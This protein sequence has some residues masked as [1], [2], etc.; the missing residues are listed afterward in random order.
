MARVGLGAEL[1]PIRQTLLAFAAAASG[2]PEQT[3]PLTSV[4]AKQVLDELARAEAAVEGLYLLI[5]RGVLV[6]NTAGDHDFQSYYKQAATLVT[7][8]HA[9]ALVLDQRPKP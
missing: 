6:R 3:I 5:E 4:Q 9:A 1:T 7:A 2:L 8:V